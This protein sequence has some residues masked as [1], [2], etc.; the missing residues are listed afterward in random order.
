M[1]GLSLVLLLFLNEEK[2][3]RKK[4]CEETN[5]ATEKMEETDMLLPRE[6]GH[7]P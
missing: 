4:I 3:E 2:G 6:E 5:G 7:S 1:L